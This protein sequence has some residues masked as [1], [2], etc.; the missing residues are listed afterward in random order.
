ML[1]RREPWVADSSALWRAHDEG[2]LRGYV[3]AS[4]ITDI[5]YVARKLVGVEVARKAVGTCPATFEICGVDR[6]ELERAQALRASDFEDNLQM[7]CAELTHLDAIITRDGSGF[8]GSS[9]PALT[10]TEALSRLR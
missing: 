5:F 1:L 7:A 3:M 8:G 10:P 4:A 6:A 2:R 9:V